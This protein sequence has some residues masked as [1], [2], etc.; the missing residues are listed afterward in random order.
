VPPGAAFLPKIDGVFYRAINLNGPPL[1]IDG[2]SWE[3]GSGAPRFSAKGSPVEN[4]N[5][6]L[7]PATDESRSRMLR[8]ALTGTEALTCTFSE[9]PPGNY[10]VC[11]YVWEGS[12]NPKMFDVHLQ[13]KVAV[14]N[15][16]TGQSG[17]WQ[18]FGPW[19]AL[20]VSDGQL[21]FVCS[22][23]GVTVC[24]IEVWKKE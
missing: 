13:G 5:G 14:S 6:P 15:F 17:Q 12:G 3:G 10:W 4:R 23:N 16:S 7:I 24:G 20:V 1:P 9:V 2:N 21:T 19:S 18:R 8:T 22:G 11:I